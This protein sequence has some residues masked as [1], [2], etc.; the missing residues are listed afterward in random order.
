MRTPSTIISRRRLNAAALLTLGLAASA[1]FAADPIKVRMSFDDDM[2]VTRLADSLGYF[3]QED[4][5]IVP[6]DI[7]VEWRIGEFEILR[8]EPSRPC[9]E[10]P[11]HHLVGVVAVKCKDRSDFGGVTLI[12][13]LLQI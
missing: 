1:A 10:L 3:K 7:L 6:V 11:K 2:V 9:L 5:E 13:G 12:Q 4:I 8:V